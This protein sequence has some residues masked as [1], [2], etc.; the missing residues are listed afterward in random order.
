[1]SV[2]TYKCPSCGAGIAFDSASQR[3]KCEYCLSEF[4]EEE[5]RNRTDGGAPAEES[6]SDEAENQAYCDGLISYTCSNCGAEVF[7]DE[8]T[9][10]DICYYCHNPVVC[11]G[12]L[13]GQLRPH[14]IIPFAY[15]QEEAKSR[16]LAFA[17]R[18]WFVPRDFF[19]EAH[20][21]QIRGVYFPFWLTD[22]DVTASASANATRVRT[23]K[24]GNKLYTET[25]HYRLFRRGGIHFEDIATSAYSGDDKKMLEG[26]LP[27][28]PEALKEFTMTYLSGFLA[29]KRNIE[30][31]RVENEV[32]GRINRYSTTLLSGTMS[33]YTTVTGVNCNARLEK[34]I[35]DYALMPLWILTY[36]KS[37]KTYTY[38]MNGH[39]GKI[40]G[41][42]PVSGGKLLALFGSLLVGVSVL[43]TLIG[44]LLL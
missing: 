39:T 31:D 21:E 23:W 27:F 13:T 15:D 42:L 18:K 19:S 7:A 25:S 40:Y 4:T 37:G 11:S 14:K 5:I 24:A 33:G 12:R 6:R 22:A 32:R 35:W 1:M 44:G 16:F 17:R 36:Q 41:E 9:A 43:C 20:A 2:V 8:N 28:P 3:F 26:I 30:R 10:A 29:K 38:A 34:Y